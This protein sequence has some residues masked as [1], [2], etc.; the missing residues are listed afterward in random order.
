MD[1]ILSAEEIWAAD[2]IREDTVEIPEWGGSVRVRALDL[3]QI[4]AVA[5]SAMKRNPKT[6]QEELDRKLSMLYTLIEGMVEP[7]LTI[8]DAR[9][10]E[11]KS[12][13]AVTRIVQAINNLG[14]TE[15]AIDG[16]A[17]SDA[18]ELNGALSVLVGTRTQDD[19]RDVDEDSFHL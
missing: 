3:T 17:K 5:T 9:N 19:A 12:A 14:A 2:D 4:A 13:T 6:N 1:H 8:A 7:K 11:K 15:E 16:A 18:P 10:L